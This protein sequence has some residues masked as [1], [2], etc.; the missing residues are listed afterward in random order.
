MRHSVWKRHR[1]GSFEARKDVFTSFASGKDMWYANTVRV[2]LPSKPA[3]HVQYSIG[4]ASFGFGDLM[5]LMAGRD[6][7]GK[8]T[9]SS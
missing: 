9:A 6:V 3:V 1:M 8:K 5:A 2:K 7:D 4:C